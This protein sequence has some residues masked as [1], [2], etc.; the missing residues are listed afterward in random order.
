MYSFMDKSKRAARPAAAPKAKAAKTPIAKP[1]VA[2]KNVVEKAEAHYNAQLLACKNAE[3][4][5]A[6]KTVLYPLQAAAKIA[7]AQLKIEKVKYKLA[8]FN[9]NQAQKKADKAKDNAV[10]STA[11]KKGGK[12]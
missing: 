6:E 1:L 7:K 8:K 2:A 11:A 12:A 5:N 10:K 4:E 3:K 9:E